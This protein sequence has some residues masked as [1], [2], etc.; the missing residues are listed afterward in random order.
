[1]SYGSLSGVANIALARA[2]DLTGVIAGTGEGGLNPGVA[3]C[4]RITV[5]WASAR[6]GV[7]FGVLNTGLGIVI[8]VGQ[9]AKPGIGG[10]LPGAKV[11][12]PVSAT[13]RIPIGV[14]AISPAPHH[15]IYS[16][17]DLGQR[18]QILKEATGKPV[19]VKVGATN[20]IPYIASGVA[21]MGGDG[22]IIDASGA[23]TGAAPSVVK[24]NVGIPVEI[25]VASVDRVLRRDN[26]RDGFSVIAAGRVSSAEDAA[27]LMSL[28]ADCVSIGTA[29]LI[30]MGCVMV[31]KCNLGFCPA[32]LTN[33]I[34]KNPARL[35]SSDRCLEWTV[36]LIH[37]WTEELKLILERLGLDSVRDLA[38]RKDLLVGCNMNPETARI[39][40]IDTVASSH[41]L[42][43]A[44]PIDRS[45]FWAIGLR[46]DLQNMAGST[47]RTPGEPVISSMGSTGP[48][49]V[50]PPRRVSDWLVADGAQVTRPS[51]DPYRERID[52]ACYLATG[53]LRLS[54]PVLFAPLKRE[55]QRLG[56]AF[57]RA[58]NSM[59]LLMYV[60]DEAITN[61]MLKYTKRMI[62]PASESAKAAAYFVEGDE[63][64]EGL[65]RYA[66]KRPLYLKLSCVEESAQT[67][68]DAASRGFDGIII[69]EDAPC[70]QNRLHLEVVV[71][72]V[73]T[74][75]RGVAKDG[76]PLRNRVDLIASGSDVRHAGDI[77]KI[78]GLGADVVGI[79]R[80]AMI[81][82]GCETIPS[83]L[84]EEVAKERLENLVFALQKE[85]KLLAGA[86][87][88]TNIFT[89]LTGN[90][91]LFRSVD[92]EPDVR[93]KL[94]LKPA[95]AF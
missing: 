79:S 37:G 58:A 81:G 87:G 62:I 65:A 82:I 21:R 76:I 41:A 91:E 71:S 17:E 26:M 25:A 45:D 53:A 12:E 13:R 63:L 56:K 2:A 11:T 51:I 88:L 34:E 90:R 35:L 57:A 44:P 38:G 85:L 74:A 29:A 83:V 50:E 54:A 66:D 15:D 30:A 6:F 14:D 72:V 27:K 24:D 84:D 70:E 32:L 68:V 61:D 59:G 80:A 33:R 22:I 20:Y 67:A 49:F 1:M 93:K 86:A 55:E 3:K 7:D 10:H 89:T 46:K 31:H 75:L 47:G 60:R 36:N 73:D 4:E 16:I 95:G 69:D 48:P 8:K 52:T 28:G 18:I 94:R 77:F 78:C 39:M 5:Q 9:G 64:E 43:E 23:G 40:G 19:F 92:L 42:P